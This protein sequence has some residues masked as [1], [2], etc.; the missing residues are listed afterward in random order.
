[1]GEIFPTEMVPVTEPYFLFFQNFIEAWPDNA[2][3]VLRSG[4]IDRFTCSQCGVCCT[5]PWR[6]LIDRDYYERWYQHFDEHPSGKFKRPFVKL[7][8]DSDVQYADIRR[9]AQSN[10]CI[11]LQENNQCFIHSEYGPS[12]LSNVCR[13]YP[14][15]SLRVA[16]KYGADYLLASCQTSP[17]LISQNHDFF[18]YFETKETQRERADSQASPLEGAGFSK[19]VNLLWLGLCL[20]V[21][22]LPQNTP[23]QNLRS[24]NFS[25]SYFSERNLAEIQ[26]TELIRLY[27]EQRRISEIPLMV[28]PSQ[29]DQKTA[30][31]WFFKLIEPSFTPILNY[32][33]ALY[34]AHLPWPELGDPELLLFNDFIKNYLLRKMITLPYGDLFQQKLSFFQ[35]FFQ[36]S[37]HLVMIQVLASYYA[38]RKGKPIEL[39]DLTQAVNLVEGRYGQRRDWPEKHKINRISDLDAIE[40]MQIALSLDFGH[41]LLPVLEA[42][43]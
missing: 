7:H 28:G 22:N 21:L 19:K 8:L 14:R 17:A 3:V 27:R 39:K 36:L 41:H 26:E 35:A 38:Y 20:D 18:A 29:S 11:F 42:Q 34:H 1:L 9:Q 32:A 15:T 5:L 12:A 6:I 23:L 30:L 43:T 2:S 40:F 31:A 4:D 13:T 37:L 10:R 24:L 25:L 33:Q 16:Q